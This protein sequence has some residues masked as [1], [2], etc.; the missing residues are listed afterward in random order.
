VSK[1][2]ERMGTPGYPRTSKQYQQLVRPWRAD[3]KGFISLLD[4]HS[5][6]QSKMSEQDRQSWGASGGGY[7]AY[8]IK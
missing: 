1:I 8:L 6:E 7:G 2:Y 4:W 3:E 5:F